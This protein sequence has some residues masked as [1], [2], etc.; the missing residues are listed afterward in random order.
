MSYRSCTNTRSRCFTDT[1]SLGCPSARSSW[2][3]K[4]S[5]KEWSSAGIRVALTSRLSKYPSWNQTSPTS[6]LSLV[7]PATQT[8]FTR[9]ES[10]CIKSR[11]ANWRCTAIRTWCQRGWRET[12]RSQ[13]I[14]GSSWNNNR[15][16]RSTTRFWSAWPST[17]VPTSLDRTVWS[18]TWT[19]PSI[20]YKCV[21]QMKTAREEM[22]F[23]LNTPVLI[24]RIQRSRHRKR[25]PI[26]SS[27]A[28]TLSLTFTRRRT[29]K[30]RLGW[31]VKK[32]QVFQPFLPPQL[33]AGE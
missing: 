2:L 30:R 20:I 1:N 33:V 14:S 17:A 8:P 25:Q 32:D 18:E 31:K 10:Q 7:Y 26:N 23:L 11:R 6:F 19:T 24:S 21:L 4:W 29:G 3:L 16:R 22:K 15:R 5:R 13:A 27:T 12:S 28:Q 9:V